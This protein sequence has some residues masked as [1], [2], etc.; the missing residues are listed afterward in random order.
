MRAIARETVMGLDTERDGIR[1]VYRPALAEF[2]RGRFAAVLID[3]GTSIKAE[4]SI[5]GL[6]VRRLNARY[7]LALT[8]TPIKNR[9]PDILF[10]AAWACDALDEPNERW[11]YSAGSLARF[12]EEFQVH[13]VPS[14]P[15]PSAACSTPGL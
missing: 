10:L 1:C 15:L 11:P 2:L 3:E 4:D 12:V 6:G 5:I 13:S 7:R 14:N 9:L 8:G